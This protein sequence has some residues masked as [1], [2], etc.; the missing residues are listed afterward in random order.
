MSKDDFPVF[1]LLVSLATSIGLA[2]V[3]QAD[4]KHKVLIAAML[5]VAAALM[6][7]GIGWPWLKDW[8]PSFATFLGELAASRV[9]WFV[10]GMFVGAAV[11]F[12]VPW[13]GAKAP[14][15]SSA[16]TGTTRSPHQRA[17]RASQTPAPSPPV[18]AAKSDD[19]PSISQGVYVARV[20]VIATQLVSDRV[21][22]FGFVAFNGTGLPLRLLLPVQ[23]YVAYGSGP[24][25]DTD[26][27]TLPPPTAREGY[28]M[29]FPAYKEITVSIEQRVPGELAVEIDRALSNRERVK[30]V[31]E[32]LNILLQGE[33]QAEPVRLPVWDQITCDQVTSE[34]LGPMVNVMS[35][36]IGR[37]NV[38]L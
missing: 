1:A 14:A 18:L 33:G 25:A 17:P 27:L 36:A 5:V 37:L 28:P 3:R 30:F 4:W 12:W 31:L 35:I 22:Q 11:I 38:R 24:A 7:L 15:V 19:A 6:T 9:A 23:G 32:G 26:L 21:L 8:V 10:V 16:E 29:E 2:A 20:A 34:L 13:A